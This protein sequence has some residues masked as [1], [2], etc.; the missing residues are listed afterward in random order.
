[1]R[2]SAHQHRLTLRLEDGWYDVET[3][4]DGRWGPDPMDAYRDWAGFESWARELGTA[5][6]PEG[7][8]APDAGVTAPVPRPPQVF[9]IG[10][11]F[12]SHAVET[13]FQAPDTPMVF[14][15]FPSSV[16][17]PEDAVELSSDAVDFEVELVVVIGRRAHRV[18]RDEAWDVVAGLTVG[19]D[20]SDRRVQMRNQPPQFSM[21][22]SFPGYAPIGPDVLTPDEFEDLGAIDLACGIE[23]GETLQRGNTRDMIFDVPALIEDLSAIAV[24]EPGDLIFAGT[25]EGV[26]MSRTPQRYLAPGEVLVSSAS[27]IGQMR[28]PLVARGASEG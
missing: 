2:L 7:R 19:Q 28:N 26:G 24:L 5:P 20:L 27:V 8:T 1:M 11:N 14:T 22:K 16:A 9:A 13:N 3:L 17:G 25:P 10:L 4:S 18:G 23:G 12:V 15:K 21:G 6:R